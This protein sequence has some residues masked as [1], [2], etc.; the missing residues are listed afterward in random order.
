[1][2]WLPPPVQA[3][4]IAREAFSVPCRL[5]PRFMATEGSGTFSSLE[6][7][8]FCLSYEGLTALCQTWEV[9]AEKRAKGIEPGQGPVHCD[10]CLTRSRPSRDR[11]SEEPGCSVKQSQGLNLPSGC[12]VQDSL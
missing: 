4:F 8:K 5:Y 2:N 7:F 11:F 12:R 1:M 10:V 9:L 3:L 6:P